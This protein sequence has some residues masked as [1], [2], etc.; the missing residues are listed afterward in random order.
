LPSHL[1]SI[2]LK[3][4]FEKNKPSKKFNFTFDNKYEV[5]YMPNG[6]IISIKLSSETSYKVKILKG[7]E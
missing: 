1:K 2:F 5:C 3:T 7:S 4:Y 6:V